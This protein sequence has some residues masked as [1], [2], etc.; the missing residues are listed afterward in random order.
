MSKSNPADPPDSGRLESLVEAINEDIAA[1]RYDGAVALVAQGGNIALHRAIGESDRIQ[2]RP[3]HIDDVFHFMS[4]TK[5]L[6]TVVVLNAIEQGKFT[7]DTPVAAVIPEFGCKGKQNVT[8]YHLLTHMSGLNTELP[9]ALPP[10]GHIDLKGFVAALSDE[11]LHRR[12]GEVVCY[13]AYGAHSLLAEMVCR[14]DEAQRPFRTIL[15]ED[16]L[17][18]MGM[19]STSLSLRDDIAERR[20]PITARFGTGGI[21]EPEAFDAMNLLV[22]EEAEF[23]AAGAMGTAMD[24]YQFTEM[25]R[26]GGSLNGTRF[27]SQEMLENATRNHTGEQPNDIFAYAREMRDLPDWPAYIG[28]TFFLR[29]VG[30]FPTPMGL[31]TSADTICGQGA[32]SALFWI[33]RPRDLTF[34]CLTAGIMDEMENIYRFQRLSDLVVAALD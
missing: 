28:L 4:I 8:V 30:E 27:L 1:E 17:Q 25:L 22:T 16:L 23:A 19:H 3:A 2:A 32:G 15:R 24:L 10:G 13:N 31:N 5:Q 11:R 7:L 33:D 21:F 14:L 26:Q 29:G 6:T 20:V 9:L 34:I 18:P 12:P